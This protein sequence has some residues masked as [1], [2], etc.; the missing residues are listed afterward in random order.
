LDEAKK[1]LAEN[2]PDD[3]GAVADEASALH[4]LGE[5]KRQAAIPLI[6]PVLPVFDAEANKAQRTANDVTK[7]EIGGRVNKLSSRY[8]YYSLLS[9]CNLRR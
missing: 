7:I 5:A 6:D 8:H 2:G 3:E 1:K 4:E 9:S